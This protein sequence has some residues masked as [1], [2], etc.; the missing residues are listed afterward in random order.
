[1]IRINKGREPL[2]WS[3]KKATPGFTEFEPIAELRDALLIEQ[4]FICAYCM[5][6]IP[7]R[8]PNSDAISKI[9][10]IKSQEDRPDLQLDYSNMAICCPGKIDAEAHCDTLKLGNSVSFDL[11]SA[12]L[13]NSIKYLLKDAEIVSENDGWNDEMT[14]LLNLN[15]KRIK[16]NRKNALSGVIAGFKTTGWSRASVNAQLRKW[17]N[18]NSEGKH[19]PYCGIVIWYLQ[20]NLNQNRV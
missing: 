8:D 6:R 2:A 5:R 14:R 4:G 12:A 20:K 13:Q 17:S 9:E 18:L 3:A 10:H 1:M 15:H 11:Y 16:L 7:A 19:E